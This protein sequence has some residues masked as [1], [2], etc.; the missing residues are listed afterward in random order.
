ML[1]AYPVSGK[2]KSVDICKAFI[3]GAPKDAR[4]AVFYGVNESN[5][6]QWLAVKRR[7]DDFYYIDNAY[8]D[9]CRQIYFRVTKNAVQHSGRGTSDGRRFASL[10]FE[11]KP[12]RR[13]RQIVVI[14]QSE[15]F[16]R[17]VAGYRGDWVAD[18][19]VRM[20][21]QTDR[22][23][24]LRLWSSY[25]GQIAST[26]LDDLAGAHALVAYSSAA[27]VMAVING[28]PV[29][30]DRSSAAYPMAGSI[31]DVE[32]LP[33]PDGREQWAGVLADNQWTLDEM[34]NGTAWRM[35]HE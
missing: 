10:G 33:M 18:V 17:T 1:T 19:I 30:V 31:D 27:A 4:G 22:S 6:E 32:C 15:S 29:A 23:L 21:E 26:L 14:Q 34:R 16:M 3:A 13:G 11:I 35:L 20:A 7:G 12:W 25:K 2:Q 24:V 9:S 28:V 5:V 8:F